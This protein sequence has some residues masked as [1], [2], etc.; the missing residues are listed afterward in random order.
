MVNR[1][2]QW[3]SNGE[4]YGRTQYGKANTGSNPVLTTN[5]KIFYMAE[6]SMFDQVYGMYKSASETS[7][8]MASCI[9]VLRS[10]NSSH[11]E[12]LEQLWRNTRK[13]DLKDNI[14][15]QLKLCRRS[16]RIAEYFWENRNKG[17]HIEWNE[18]VEAVNRIETQFKTV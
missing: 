5:Q 2:L 4:L 3:L 15:R 17:S 11:E 9:G 13:K 18:A 8:N 16:M 12:F 1:H 6:L 10:I 14:E 7:G